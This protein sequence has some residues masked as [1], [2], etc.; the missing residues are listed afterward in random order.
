MI[1]EASWPDTSAGRIPVLPVRRLLLLLLL[2]L[3][4]QQHD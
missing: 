2:L 3:L 1:L 4:L